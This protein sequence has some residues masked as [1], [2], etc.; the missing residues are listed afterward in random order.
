MLQLCEGGLYG[1]CVGF[2]EL[3][4]E[5]FQC[6]GGAEGRGDRCGAD[7]IGMVCV[8]EGELHGGV[9]IC[10]GIVGGDHRAHEWCGDVG[11]EVLGDLCG[12]LHTA[13]RH[14]I[15]KRSEW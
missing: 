11:C 2:V 9:D 13:V 10:A 14:E 7:C 5:V 12:R 1:L 8:E 3:C 15:Q 4:G 6:F